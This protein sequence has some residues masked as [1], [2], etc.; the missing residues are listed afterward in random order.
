MGHAYGHGQCFYRTELLK[1]GIR[2]GRCRVYAEVRKAA[3]ALRDP[4]YFQAQEKQ[5]NQA[6]NLAGITRE[7]VCMAAAVTRGSMRALGLDSTSVRDRDD[8]TEQ[9]DE[10]TEHAEDERQT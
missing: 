8:S 10:S 7:H 4:G 9:A 1:R 5:F 2:S 6:L 3:I